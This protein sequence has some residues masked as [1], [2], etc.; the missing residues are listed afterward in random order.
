MGNCGGGFFIATQ[1]RGAKEM[2]LHDNWPHPGISQLDWENYQNSEP[3]AYYPE[4]PVA[5]PRSVPVKWDWHW[6]QRMMQ[7]QREERQRRHVKVRRRLGLLKWLGR[8]M[9]D[10][11]F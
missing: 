7:R 5:R 9:D 1:R 2:Y 8:L 10:A 6:K 3:V 11:N 4:R